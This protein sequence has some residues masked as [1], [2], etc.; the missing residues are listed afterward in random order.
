MNCQCRDISRFNSSLFLSCT[1]MNWTQAIMHASSTFLFFGQTITHHLYWSLLFT[2]SPP[3]EVISQYSSSVINYLNL[4]KTLF[5]AG[6]CDLC[7]NIWVSQH[8]VCLWDFEGTPFMRSPK[9]C[10]S[11]PHFHLDRFS[12][13]ILSIRYGEE[14]NRLINIIPAIIFRVRVGTSL[15]PASRSSKH[16]SA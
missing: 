4:F 7:I 12:T 2:S 15:M 9:K 6:A 13:N 5:S 3:R 16:C 14:T 8:S 1:A 11:S 10:Y